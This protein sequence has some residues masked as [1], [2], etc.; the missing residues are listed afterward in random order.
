MHAGGEGA[1]AEAAVVADVDAALDRGIA[2]GLGDAAAAIVRDQDEFG[3]NM[4][5]RGRR[6]GSAPASFSPAA[7]VTPFSTR[8]SNTKASPDGLGRRG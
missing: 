4:E 8:D 1:D 5:V 3:R 2:V 7:Q 6:A